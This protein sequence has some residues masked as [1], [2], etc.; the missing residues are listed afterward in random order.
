MPY[1]HQKRDLCCKG[2]LF[3][4]CLS[5]N[6]VRL[7]ASNLGLHYLTFLVE[8]SI[9]KR[10]HKSL[11]QS[12]I[13]NSRMKNIEDFKVSIEVA[14]LMYYN[15]AVGIFLSITNILTAIRNTNKNTSSLF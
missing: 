6:S 3:F 12:I 8:Y 11:Q 7:R 2:L 9:R 13:L 4:K 1:F 5:V 14:E 10:L 15:P